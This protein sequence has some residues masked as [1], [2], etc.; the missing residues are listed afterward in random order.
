MKPVAF[1]YLAAD[2]VEAAISALGRAGG[3]GKILAGGQSLMPMLNFRLVRPSLLIDINPIGG[4]AYIE[5]GD[6]AISIGALTRHRRLETSP[7]VATH[8]PV[9]AAAM[10][11]VAHLP[12]RNRGT[13]GGSLSH[14][15][16]AAELPMMA[17]LL[18]A[19]IK[20]QSPRG[21]RVAA[22]RDFFLGSLTTDLRE[23][24]ILISV[25]FPK[26]PPG[27]GWAFEE[28]ARRAGDFALAA[29]GVT[30]LRS[31]DSSQR[32]SIALM[33]VADTPLRAAEAEALLSGRVLDSRLI[34]AAA[35][36]IKASV[37]PN[38]DL[39]ASGDYRRHL[40]ATLAGRAIEAAWH[41]ARRIGQ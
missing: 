2:S 34:D 4:L 30:I 22:A 27:T 41:R 18:D 9:L 13:L 8:L 40:V 35:A 15:D 36:A 33:G 16:P 10:G 21:C 14:A 23:D 26:L 12:I 7:I 25:E 5:E 32:V 17:L 37:E 20:I 11:H 31:D 19:K 1:D 24:E 3:E 29:V 6:T 38:S 28:V 39:H